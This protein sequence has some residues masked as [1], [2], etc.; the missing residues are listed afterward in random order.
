MRTVKLHG[1]LGKRFGETWSLDVGSPAEAARAIEANRPGFISYLVESGDSGIAYQILVGGTALDKDEQ[2]QQP[3]GAQETLEFVPVPA[4]SKSSWLGIAIGVLLMFV[5]PYLS[6]TVLITGTT[7]SVSSIAFSVG[8]SLALGGVAQMLAG[9][10]K[11]ELS[12]GTAAE[13]RN[14]FYFSGPV[15]TS[16]QGLPVPIGYGELIVGSHRLSVGLTSKDIL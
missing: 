1:E 15:N 3:F 8:L 7:I 9:T 6:T 5:A 13:S 12:Q 16:E 10:P 2:V 11:N 4:G 14:S